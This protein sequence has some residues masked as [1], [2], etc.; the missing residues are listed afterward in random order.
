MQLTNRTY[1]E[2]VA[3]LSQIIE[4][5]E[6]NTNQQVDEV[7]GKVARYLDELANYINDSNVIIDMNVS[8]AVLSCSP[9]PLL[10][11]NEIKSKNDKAL[12]AFKLPDCNEFFHVIEDVVDV[13]NSL[14]QWQPENIVV[15][16][17]SIC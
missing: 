7:L 6:N 15:A 2:A 5:T 14:L 10:K 9:P 12:L 11:C 3:M 16:S 17:S 4:V 8:E 1:V 13:L